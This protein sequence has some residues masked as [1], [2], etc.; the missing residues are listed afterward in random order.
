MTQTKLF[1]SVF[2]QLLIFWLFT[3]IHM[4][5]TNYELTYSKCVSGYCFTSKHIS[6]DVVDFFGDLLKNVLILMFWTI[7]TLCYI[8]VMQCYLHELN[9]SA[10]QQ[11]DAFFTAMFMKYMQLKSLHACLWSLQ[12][13]YATYLTTIM[14]TMI[15]NLIAS[16]WSQY[17][18]YMR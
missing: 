8:H 6:M 18:V 17:C 14:V 16:I 3:I 11:C 15:L 10:L 12:L 13:A 4:R 1:T 5:S 2:M 7:K 9:L